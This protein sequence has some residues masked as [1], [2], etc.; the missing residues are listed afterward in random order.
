MIE[1]AEKSGALP[2][3]G[4]IC[5]G[6][7]GNT[8]VSLAALGISRGYKVDNTA[9][10]EEL[11]YVHPQYSLNNVFS[12]L[13]NMFAQICYQ[14]VLA[15]PNSIAEEKINHQKRLGAEVS[16]VLCCLSFSTASLYS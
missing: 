6:T 14:V 10:N 9:Q 15:M 13:H 16:H 1:A 5:E 8:G 2:P 3:G 12:F 4:T 7:G 11:S